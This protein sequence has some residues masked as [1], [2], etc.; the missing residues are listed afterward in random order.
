M[1]AYV[2][3]VS[4][5]EPRNWERCKEAQLWGVPGLSRPAPKV[6]TGD[7]LFI[8]KGRAGFMAEAVVT[9]P[10]RVPQTREEAPWPGGLGRWRAV[11]PIRIVREVT[12]SYKLPFVHDR[13]EVTGISSNSL[14]FGLVHISDDAAATISSVLAERDTV[15]TA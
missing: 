14:R 9:G 15:P 8:W 11:F 1:T 4:A 2:G 6:E 13:Q 10:A 7:R 5:S 12:E 3:A